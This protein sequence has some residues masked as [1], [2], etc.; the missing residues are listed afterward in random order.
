M[1]DYPDF[2]DDISFVSSGK[3]LMMTFVKKKIQS[4]SMKMLWMK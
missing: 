4:C 1:K 2:V 3:N